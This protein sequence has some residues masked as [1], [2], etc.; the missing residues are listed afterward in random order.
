MLRP[1]SLIQVTPLGG[2]EL[3]SPN[4]CNT[5]LNRPEMPTKQRYSKNCHPESCLDQVHVSLSMAFFCY[6]AV[7]GVSGL[8]EFVLQRLGDSISFP[9]MGV[10]CISDNGHNIDFWTR[11]ELEPEKVDKSNPLGLYFVILC[12][13]V[14]VCVCVCARVHLHACVF[15]HLLTDEDCIF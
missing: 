11:W 6:S 12:V 4:R 3:L 1:L 13:C 8:L 5:D 10:T 14:C 7:V 9:P 15:V 2:K